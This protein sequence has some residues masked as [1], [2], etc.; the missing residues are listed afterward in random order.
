L[1]EKAYCIGSTQTH[2][3]LVSRLCTAA[4]ARALSVEYRL[5]SENP[6]PAAVDD[7]LA[8]Y[9]W[10]RSQGVSARS[11]V[12]AGDSAGGG[13]VLAADNPDSLSI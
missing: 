3:D 13:L 5:A 2:R 10:L 6:F 7:G 4:S 8:A 12:V 1:K 11:I 9:R